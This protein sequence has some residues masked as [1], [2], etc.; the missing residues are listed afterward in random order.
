MNAVEASDIEK[1]EPPPSRAKTVYGL[2]AAAV[3][4]SLTMI[5]YEQSIARRLE[6]AEKSAGERITGIT[7]DV[8]TSGLVSLGFIVLGLRLRT[9]LG[10]GILLLNDWPSID[11]DARRRVRST[12][13][14][15]VAIGI[16]MDVIVAIVSY[17][18]EPMLPKPRVPLATPPAWTGF[19]ASIGAGIQEEIWMRL[20]IMTLFVWIGNKIVRRTSPASGVV[21][22]ANVL[23]AI[24][25]GA[26]HLP[27]AALFFGLSAPVVA[28]TLLGNGLPGVVLGWLYWR[29]GLVAA[30]LAH[31]S[32]DC[33]LH[34][35]V[36]LLGLG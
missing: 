4:G 17:F 16:G 1:T 35:I 26:I 2:L 5:P 10:V 34:G 21:W 13:A 15:A 12:I 19:L 25:F 23:A 3:L 22:T 31:F 14:L 9:S 7:Q 29:R 27:Q 32:A 18:V 6:R 33:V 30:M 11:A 20:G 28:Y 8:L 36:P 24:L